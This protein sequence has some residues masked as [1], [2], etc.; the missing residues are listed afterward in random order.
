[1]V[2][3][4]DGGTDEPLTTP[5]EATRCWHRQG[6]GHVSRLRVLILGYGFAG[7]WIH[8]PVIRSVPE[9]VVTGVVT[10]D[11]KRRRLAESRHPG[12]TVFSTPEDA[13]EKAEADVAVVAT[14]NHRHVELTLAAF[15]A[16]MDV[17]VD[18]PLASTAGECDRL[19]EESRRQGRSLA[20]FHNRRWDGDYLTIKR[21]VDEGR[22]GAVHRLTSRFDRWLP[23]PSPGWRDT[24]PEQGGGLL[25]DLGSHLVDQAIRLLGPVS[26]VYA[27][28]RTLHPS[29]QSD[30]DM[31][32]AL[33][34]SSGATSHLYAGSHEGDP[35]LRFRVSGSEGTYLKRGKDVQEERLLAGVLPVPGE[36]GV[37]PRE[38]WGRIFRGEDS[39]EVETVPGDWSAFYRDLV[40]HLTEGASLPVSGTEAREVLTVLDAARSSDLSGEVVAPGET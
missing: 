32:V 10:S 21:L 16:G 37:E 17:V 6:G 36:T 30:D 8:D 18:K 5:G 9:L 3:A 38:A 22:L 2:G 26:R 4:T 12:V 33:T 27:E 24:T 39:E 15:E 13:F 20:V 40:A 31:F 29:R 23:N 25:L 19:V 1:V 28:L 14:P 7:A 35:S 34:H 11:P